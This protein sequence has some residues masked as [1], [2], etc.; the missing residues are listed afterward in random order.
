MN[1]KSGNE[2]SSYTRYVVMLL[3]KLG[4]YNQT[5]SSIKLKLLKLLYLHG[6]SFPI[7]QLFW[8]I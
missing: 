5:N 7:S 3:P 1:M 8:A 6:V 4:I 2:D